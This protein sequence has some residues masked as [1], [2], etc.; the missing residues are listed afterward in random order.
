MDI[1]CA[2]CGEPWDVVHLR[3]DTHWVECE[4]CDRTLVRDPD[5]GWRVHHRDDAPYG[6]CEH[7]HRQ[8]HVEPAYTGQVPARVAHWTWSGRPG[9][10]R[11]V[12]AGMGCPACFNAN[13]PARPTRSAW[14]DVL[15]TALEGLFDTGL[16]RP[17]RIRTGPA[18]GQQ[19]SQQR[20]AGAR[21]CHDPKP[22]PRT[23]VLAT[24][25]TDTDRADADGYD[26]EDTLMGEHATL[27]AYAYVRIDT[28][29]WIEQRTGGADT[30]LTTALQEWGGQYPF[31]A[32]PHPGWD[33]R[34]HLW[35][36]ARGYATAEGG[37]IMHT[38]TWLDRDVWILLADGGEAGALAIVGGGRD[39]PTV[40]VDAT[41]DSGYWF[42]AS[43]VDLFCPGG[44][45]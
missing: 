40:Y 29:A 22:P 5:G 44:H 28:D 2:R 35:C 27:D 19:S 7:R 3:E 37:V 36:Q 16:S 11:F 12:A 23:R 25:S 1:C 30:G 33:T 34:A 39:A 10:L 4:D 18:A 13:P 41:T 8:L 31:T 38:D 17:S 9:W 15:D 24:P 32:Y 45:R 20:R 26:E 43:T 21:I 6:W 42:D 14:V